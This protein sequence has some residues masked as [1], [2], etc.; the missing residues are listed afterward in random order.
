MTAD[1][2]AAGSTADMTAAGRE[3][4]ASPIAVVERYFEAIDAE[5]YETLRRLM[6][7]DVTIT[8]CGSRPRDGIDAVIRFFEAIFK[9]FPTHSDRPRRLLRDG[10]TVV[11]EIHFEGRSVGGVDVSFEAVDVFDVADGRIVRLTQWLDSA[12]LQRRLA[13]GK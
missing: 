9:R 5:D 4:P 12:D 2:A 8:A 1:M 7:P 6:H 3:R 11:A 10:D 13:S